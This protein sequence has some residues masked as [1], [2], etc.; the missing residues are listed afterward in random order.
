MSRKLFSFRPAPLGLFILCLAG[1]G[2]DALTDAIEQGAEAMAQEPGQ[3]HGGAPL[4]E[5]DKLGNKLSGY[6]KCVNDTSRDVQRAQKRYGDWVDMKTGPTGTE[7][8]V[9]GLFAMRDHKACREAVT[10][11]QAAEPSMP[12]LEAAA[13]AYVK[14]LDAIEPVVAE[15][16][17]YYDDK[18]YK[19]DAFAKGK[20]LHPKLVASFAAFE[21]ADAALRGEVKTTNEGLLDRELARVEQ[22]EGRKLLFLTKNVMAT[23]KKLIAA[24]DSTSFETLDLAKLTEALKHYEAALDEYKAYKK[25]HSAE[26]GSVTALSWFDS[27]ADDFKKQT[28]S[29]MR[30]KRDDKPW[31][32]AELEKVST[33]G[34]EGHPAE[35]SKKYNALVSKSN[36]LGWNRYQPE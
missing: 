2:C 15:A 23:A 8:H 11:G 25:A 31:T 34:V 14:A 20:T 5:D 33:F 24:S 29:L 18:D 26:A 36:G 16:F 22:E 12:K 10:A 28:K 19:D 6:I 27:A 30:R 4:S 17:K 35:I 13:T 3:A 32:D 21:Q 7:K 9:F 1:T